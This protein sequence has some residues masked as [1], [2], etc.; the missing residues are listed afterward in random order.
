MYAIT[1]ITGKV[2]GAAASALL[3]AGHKVRAVVRDEDK[4]TPWSDLGCEVAIA[5]MEDGE[6]L[7]RAFT[8]VTG[9]FVL[10]PP[11]FD[12][13][14]GFPEAKAIISAVRRALF[15]THPAKVAS[16]P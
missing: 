7:T 15:A 2:G 10:P 14:P 6:A 11:N 13:E 5:D 12:P 8:D 3:S 1:G 4:G 9:V 16:L